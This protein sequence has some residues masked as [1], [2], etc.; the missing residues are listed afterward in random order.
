MPEG[1]PS[2]STTTRS[3]I[4]YGEDCGFC[5]WF[6]SKILVWDRR[7]NLR[8]VSLQS[9]ESDELLGGMDEKGKMGS[10]H[11]VTPDGRIHSAGAAA[12]PLFKILPFARPLSW[13]AWLFP[14][15]TGWIYQYFA[16]H[17]DWF[18]SKLGA[19]ACAVDPS[20]V[21]LEESSV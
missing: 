20:S 13:L 4:L 2:M 7:N 19:D 16:D 17:R 10:W 11:L 21:K 9:S 6:L 18:G 14:G 5:R 3:V 12:V 8:P 1:V 15:I